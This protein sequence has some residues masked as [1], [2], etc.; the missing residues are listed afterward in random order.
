MFLSHIDVSLS[1]KKERKIKK[2]EREDGWVGGR[3]VGT[4]KTG[5]VGGG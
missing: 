5:M 2:N 4:V 1:L 3:D